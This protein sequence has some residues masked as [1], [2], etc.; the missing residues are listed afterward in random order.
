MATKK[1]SSLAGAADLLP[2]ILKRSLETLGE[3]SLATASA[4]AEA[5]I[6]SARHMVKFQRAGVKAGMGLVSKVQKFTEKSLHDAVKDGKW[7]PKE[8]KEVVDEW[9]KTMKSGVD[10]FSRVTDK[11]FDLLLN[12]LDRVEKDQKAKSSEKKQ[13]ASKSSTAKTATSASKKKAP[14][15]RK[16]AAKK[17]SAAGK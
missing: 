15:K 14:A 9:S 10:E 12:F 11:S 6:A 13:S 8:G 16:T 3:V 17:K 7:L 2:E 4:S 5:S 1:K